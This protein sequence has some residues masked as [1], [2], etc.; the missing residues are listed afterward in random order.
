MELSDDA[1]DCIDEIAAP[2]TTV[3]PADAESSYRQV[4]EFRCYRR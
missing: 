1:F 3:N 4:G 2:G